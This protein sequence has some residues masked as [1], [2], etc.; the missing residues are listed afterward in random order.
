MN[1]QNHINSEIGSQKYAATN[2]R[3]HDWKDCRHDAI[4]KN[5]MAS[6]LG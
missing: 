6:Q 2:Q 3:L 1:T 4:Q 5:N